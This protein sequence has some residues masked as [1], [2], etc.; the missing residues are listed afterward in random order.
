MNSIIENEGKPDYWTKVFSRD[1][2]DTG[3]RKKINELIRDEQIK[4]HKW[5]ESEISR[6]SLVFGYYLKPIHNGSAYELY[7]ARKEKACEVS[8]MIMHIN[9]FQYKDLK[10]RKTSE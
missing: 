4:F 6:H 5:L 9:Q 7:T 8:T 10:W 2:G 3:L 1:H